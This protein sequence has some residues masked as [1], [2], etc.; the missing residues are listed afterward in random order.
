MISLQR[1]AASA[2]LP[3]RGDSRPDPSNAASTCSSERSTC[4]S[5]RSTCSSERSTFSSEHPTRAGVFGR[6]RLA[7]S[8]AALAAR[9]GAVEVAWCLGRDEAPPCP[10]EAALEASS[11]EAVPS[12]LRWAAER[13]VDLVIGS[14]GW[15]PSALA[16]FRGAG[17][18]ILVAP[19]FSLA[20][21]F[22]R[23]A[24]LA[25]ARFAD[26]DPGS[27]LS[28][29]ERH[30]RGK[31]DAP[32]GTAKELAAAVAAGCPRYSGWSLSSASPGAVPIAS[33]RAGS[34]VGYHELRLESGSETILL[35]HEALSREVF[36][37][38]A[39]R[40][41]AWIRGRRGVFAFDDMAAEILDPI[42][43]S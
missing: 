4:S 8:V 1:N 18:G 39:L 25:L 26:L 12:R 17:I 23:R 29:S 41:L 16:P 31:A 24:A 6:G 5:E 40:A 22:M 30:R 19:N 35:S 11:G 37:A 20:V 38:G 13:G 15:D 36:A 27:E 43:R 28:I 33:L 3:R 42:L 7:S 34:C 10:V 21:A 2:A 9:G 32:S 14:T